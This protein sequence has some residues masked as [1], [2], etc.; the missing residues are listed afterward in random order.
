MAEQERDRQ[1]E[2]RRPAQ[3]AGLAPIEPRVRDQDRDAADDEAGEGGGV[4][5]VCD[6]DVRGV[7]KAADRGLARRQCDVRCDR[8]RGHVRGP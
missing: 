7:T 6:A 5:P 1:V 2:Q 4:D 8:V 3:R